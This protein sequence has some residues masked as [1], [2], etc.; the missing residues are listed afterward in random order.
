MLLNIFVLSSN[1][2]KKTCS[3]FIDAKREVRPQATSRI[4]F[5]LN[6]FMLAILVEK[7]RIMLDDDVGKCRGGLWEGGG[8]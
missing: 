3:F 2:G 7:C 4:Y 1:P 6:N 8:P 5:L